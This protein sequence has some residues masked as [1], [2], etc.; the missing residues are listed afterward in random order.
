MATP[1]HELSSS[2]PTPHQP[3]DMQE[4]SHSEEDYGLPELWALIS[5]GSFTLA[6]PHAVTYLQ[7]V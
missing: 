2:L 4:P 7:Y 3:F 6:S 5:L 1:P